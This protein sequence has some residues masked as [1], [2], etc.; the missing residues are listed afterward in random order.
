M[1]SKKSPVKLL[2]KEKFPKGLF[3]IPEPPL[4]LYIRGEFPN[5]EKIF[6]AIV[7]SRR[8]T[9]YGRDVCKKL[10]EGLKGYPIVIVSGLALGTDSNAHE[11]AIDAGLTTIAV[12]GSG[13]NPDI[14]YPRSNIK[15]AE[16]I[17][18]NGGCLISEF[19]PDAKSEIYMFPKRNRIM[20]G[21]S[22][23]VLIIEAQEKSGTL[24]TARL[25]T[26]Y[27]R[28]VLAVPGSIFSPTSLGTNKLLR[29]GAT[30]IATSS[31]ILEALG[32]ERDEKKPT[33][34]ELFK[35]CSPNERKVLEILT[36]PLAR[37]ELLRAM[38]MPISEAS[39]ILSL[40][41]IKELIK[42]EYGEIQ[43]IY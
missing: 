28:E 2:S 22:K 4:K 13:I 3:E 19:E 6:L 34:E 8:C 10:V 38:D 12:P 25:A 35:D 17:L 32:F 1:S 31:D 20:A 33:Q 15:L 16:K 18:E 7:G 43:R 30:P 40:M 41:E 39:G 42:E 14:L 24:I 5:E 26:D 21:M 27:N 11:A 9:S 37:D 36:E 29:L 23:A